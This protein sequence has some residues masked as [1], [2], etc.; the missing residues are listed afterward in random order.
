[1]YLSIL[2]LS[3]SLIA[4]S[5]AAVETLTPQFFPSH[6]SQRVRISYGPYTVPA[7]DAET[8]GM[9]NFRSRSVE[10]PCTDCLLTF[11]QAGLEYPDGTE[12]TAE[13]GMWL[14]HTV[15]SNTMRKSLT[16]PES[17]GGDRFFASGNEKTAMDICNSG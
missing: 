16:C 6:N 1:M 13:N 11:I 2:A 15:F 7:M 4:L 5:N 10:L 9:K 14:H 17:R 8:N 3:I 12:A